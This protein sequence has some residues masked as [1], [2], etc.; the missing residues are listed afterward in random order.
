[1]QNAPRGPENGAKTRPIAR[2]G[3]FRGAGNGEREARARRGGAAPR[4][5][6]EN[7]LFAKILFFVE[8]CGELWGKFL[9]FGV[10]II[11]H[12]R[13]MRF[14]GNIEAKID[15][16]GRAFLPAAF[17]RKLQDGS[18]E[19]LVMRKDVFQPCLVLYPESAWNEQ[20]ERLRARLNRW[21]SGHQGLFRQFV[22]DAEV[23]ALDASGRLLIPRRYL[24]MAGISQAIRFIGMDDT[25]EIWSA[26][27]AEGAFIEPGDFG[28]RLGCIMAGGDAA[29]GG[30]P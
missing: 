6:G 5:G 20:T 4:S 3:A 18:G 1:M 9:N 16:K 15:A 10:E 12:R 7:T 26:E 25:I 19:C 29:D 13:P 21:D 27:L 23:V 22:S 8:N 24:R 2:T 30:E 17:R 14:L 28:A 11:K